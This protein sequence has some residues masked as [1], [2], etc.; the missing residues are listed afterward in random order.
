MQPLMLHYG[1]RYALWSDMLRGHTDRLFVAAEDRP[2]IGNTVALA[3]RLPEHSLPVVVRGTVVGWRAKSERFARGIFVRI[4]DDELEKCRRFL[5]LER[6]DVDVTSGRKVLRVHLETSAKL[7][8]PWGEETALVRNVSESGLLVQTPTPMPEGG[9]LELSL[10]LDAHGAPLRAEAVV[11][12]SYPE[13]ATAALHFV[14]L[15]AAEREQLHGYIEALVAARDVEAPGTRPILVADDEPAILKFLAAALSRHGAD[16][17]QATTGE[18]T[19]RLARELRPALVLMD[20]LMP[21]VDGADVCKS[22]RADA[23]L[24]DIPVIFVSALP[25]KTLHQVADESGATDYVLK[26]V[27]LGDLINVVGRYLRT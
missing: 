22:L 12:W 13:R 8:A 3:I 16:V 19:L 23:E 6:H 1:D 18:E 9:R 24:A 2:A 7:V 10:Q 25:E 26:P 15:S 21:G 20:I 27:G 14:D 5:G 17:Y 11:A 4:T